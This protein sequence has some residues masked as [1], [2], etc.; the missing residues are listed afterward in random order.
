VKPEPYT[1]TLPAV[2]PSYCKIGAHLAEGGV[3]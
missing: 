1:S 3:P 2:F